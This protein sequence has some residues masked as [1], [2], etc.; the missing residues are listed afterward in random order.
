LEASY[1]KFLTNT[2]PQEKETHKIEEKEKKL[3]KPKEEEKEQRK[4]K[5]SRPLLFSSSPL[6]Q[7]NPSP[8]P[9][10]FPSYR[11]VSTTEKERRVTQFKRCN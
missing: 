8:S 4:R 6:P 1:S 7:S 2:D 10:S 3:I 9:S 11:E 5:S